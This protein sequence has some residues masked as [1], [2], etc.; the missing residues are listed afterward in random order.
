MTGV[1]G[2]FDVV[3][4][5]EVLCCAAVLAAVRVSDEGLLAYLSPLGGVVDAVSSPLFG[6]LFSPSVTAWPVALPLGRAVL[7]DGGAMVG[8]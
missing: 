6:G 3:V 1:F 8:V 2:D 7:A 4:D 5:D